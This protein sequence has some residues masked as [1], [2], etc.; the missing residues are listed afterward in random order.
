[1]QPPNK[2]A[3]SITTQGFVVSVI[4]QIPKTAITSYHLLPSRLYWRLWNF[5]KSTALHRPRTLTAGG[6]LHPAPKTAIYFISIVCT[7]SQFVNSRKKIFPLTG[8]C[9]PRHYHPPPVAPVAAPTVHTGAPAPHAGK[10][11]A[12]SIPALLHNPPQFQAA[13]AVR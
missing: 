4:L 1:M 7:Q 10:Q 11:A 13:Q 9:P 2:K 6:E 5:T 3:L 12:A 8:F